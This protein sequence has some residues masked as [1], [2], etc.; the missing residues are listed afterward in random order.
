MHLDDPLELLLQSEE[1]KQP[2]VVWKV[3]EKINITVGSVFA[4]RDA[5]E[6]TE[7][8]ASRTFN[9]A[10]ECP[11]MPPQPAAQSGVRQP[12]PDVVRGLQTE[13]QP[14]ARP[15]YQS[16]G[17]RQGGL[18]LASLVRA[19]DALRDPCPSREVRL[20]QSG[21]HSSLTQQRPGIHAEKIS[22]S[23]DGLV[24]LG[25][26]LAGVVPQ[27]ST[28]AFGGGRRSVAAAPQTLKRNSTAWLSGFRLQDLRLAA[29]NSTRSCV[30]GTVGL[31]PWRS[32][33]ARAL[34]TAL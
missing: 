8:A 31:A 6:D 15:G 17:G 22:L 24:A 14:T 4:A 13:R 5:A 10:E 34:R 26:R 3:D 1:R 27:R 32:A 21:S 20:R 28:G 25:T 33:C 16:D 7:I 29:E 18:A 9:S 30:A 19:H 23:V 11:A 12:S 2:G